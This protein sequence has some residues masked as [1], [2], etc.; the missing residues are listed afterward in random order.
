VAGWYR[1]LMSSAVVGPSIYWRPG[2]HVEQDRDHIPGATVTC[3]IDRAG[4]ANRAK[5]QD[6]HAVMC[7]WT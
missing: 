2:L 3:I 4:D 1:Q 5:P 7:P 6:L